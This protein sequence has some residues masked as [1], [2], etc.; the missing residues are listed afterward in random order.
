MLGQGGR[1]RVAGQGGSVRMAGQ[2]GPSLPTTLGTPLPSLPCSTLRLRVRVRGAVR[3]HRALKIDEIR[4][5]ITFA[6]LNNP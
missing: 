4:V 6:G 5:D 3:G 1:V 2:G